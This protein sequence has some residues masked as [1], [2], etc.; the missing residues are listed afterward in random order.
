MWINRRL[1][2]LGALFAVALVA[3]AC[4][5]DAMT[6]EAAD[7]AQTDDDAVSDIQ[8][9]EMGDHDDDH[10]DDSADGEDVD[11]EHDHGA[12]T[13]DV[14]TSKPIPEVAITLDET[15]E[16]GV[17]DMTIS[18]ADF[19]ITPENV[20]GDPVDNEG[21]MHLLLDG[22]KVERFYDLE[23]QVNVPEGDHLVEV[24]LNAN[25]HLAYSI[26]SVPIRTGI[27]VAGSGHAEHDDGPDAPDANVTII[28]TLEGG[29]VSLEGDDRVK[30][31]LDDVVMIM[32]TADVEEEA[33]L[34]G[35]D[36]L[37]NV[38]PGESA[39]ILFTA[40]TAGRFE[41]EFEKSGAFIAELEVS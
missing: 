34:H 14:D 37:I 10:E 23:R 1:R 2:L 3:A 28:A 25:N 6:T 18:L 11:A 36:L 40:D 19:T 27:T 22:E 30:V 21:H 20:D 9:D 16:P 31:S 13:I 17:F 38:T 29:N 15:D 4:G 12:T 8:D 5:S 41:I 24:E 32:I 35:Y 26:D 39:M 7:A 33:H